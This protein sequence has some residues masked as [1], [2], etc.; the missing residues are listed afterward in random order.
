MPPKS[1]FLCLVSGTVKFTCLNCVC[2]CWH[3]RACEFPLRFTSL[4]HESVRPKH[5]IVSKS[6]S[7]FVRKASPIPLTSRFEPVTRL[8]WFLDWNFQTR[9]HFNR[10]ASIQFSS[11][12]TVVLF[13]ATFSCLGNNSLM[14]HSS[15]WASQELHPH[16]NPTG[17]SGPWPCAHLR[18]GAEVFMLFVLF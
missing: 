18:V 14:F 2:Q 3:S 6:S 8:S 10:V 4:F 15:D 17:I 7:S 16:I 13:K 11:G 12:N 5:K 9:L 1:F